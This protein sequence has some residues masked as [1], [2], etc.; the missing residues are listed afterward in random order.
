MDGLANAAGVLG[1][2]VS[3][4]IKSSFKDMTTESWIRLV[5]IVGACPSS[6]LISIT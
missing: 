5:I 3:T 6:L 4:N 2:R 1:N